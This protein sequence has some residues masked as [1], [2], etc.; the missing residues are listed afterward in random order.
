GAADHR[1]RPD[2]FEAAAGHSGVG[3]E[4]AA[5]HRH[6]RSV[7]VVL[8]LEAAALA[9]RY[10]AG[11]GA[12]AHRQLTECDAVLDAAAVNAGGVAGGGAAD[13]HHRPGVVLE[14][15]AEGSGVADEGAVT[16]RQRPSL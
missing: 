5:D 13:H 4:C 16:H 11:E 2:V 7:E 15:A 9:A 1:R 12:V 8:V 6:T 14:T 10:V 3:G